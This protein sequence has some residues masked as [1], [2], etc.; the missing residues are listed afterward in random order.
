MRKHIGSS[1]ITRTNGLNM[2]V[3]VCKVHGELD[4]TL[5]YKRPD[6]GSLRCNQC[7]NN[8][9]QKYMKKERSKLIQR[10]IELE[11]FVH[12][13]LKDRP[14]LIK[15][16]DS[17]MGRLKLEIETNHIAARGYLDGKC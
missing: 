11:T 17:L 1:P 13:T 16:Y 12:E 3:K 6:N 8:R 10:I 9:V 7:A 15:V 4:E 2:I 14:D 5:V